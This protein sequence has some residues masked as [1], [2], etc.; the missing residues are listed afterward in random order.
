MASNFNPSTIQR[1]SATE[2]T[3]IL[4]S[5]IF[6]TG[7]IKKQLEDRL[8]HAEDHRSTNGGKK[9]DQTNSVPSNPISSKNIS[10][11]DYITISP[12]K[13]NTKKSKTMTREK[14]K[15]EEKIEFFPVRFEKKEPH[16]FSSNPQLPIKVTADQSHKNILNFKKIIDSTIIN[17]NDDKNSNQLFIDDNL[18]IDYREIET[19]YQSYAID[20]IHIHYLNLSRK[21]D[22]L[23]HAGSDIKAEFEYN[24]LCNQKEIM[25][26]C[27]YIYMQ[28]THLIST[29]DSSIII[30]QNMTGYNKTI[31]D[32]TKLITVDKINDLRMIFLDLQYYSN[33]IFNEFAIKLGLVKKLF[34]NF[35]S[36]PDTIHNKIGQLKNIVEKLSESET[37]LL[38]NF[39][40]K[41]NCDYY[42]EFKRQPG[43]NIIPKGISSYAYH[44][45]GNITMKLYDKE[46][47]DN[48][49]TSTHINNLFNQKYKSDSS[50]IIYICPFCESDMGPIHIK[51]TIVD[52]IP[53]AKGGVDI[54]NMPEGV[55][56]LTSMISNP[57]LITDIPEKFPV[58]L[59]ANHIDKWFKTR[60]PNEIFIPTESEYEQLSDNIKSSY[61]LNDTDQNIFYVDMVFDQLIEAT[62]HN[63]IIQSDMIDSFRELVYETS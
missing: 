52:D 36:V 20:R 30:L 34:K 2:V 44:T 24:K 46:K 13:K 43:G 12:K 21:I 55:K 58:P 47:I 3:Q 4:N 59:I 25:K 28:I 62:P 60:V 56:S 35:I 51:F 33:S 14:P 29:S 31:M 16:S 39:D 6:L 40:P 38:N 9:F 17:T 26:Y 41:I 42:V 53:F 61:N 11:A 1:L 22:I 18:V 7:T 45:V 32:R 5:G 23:D 63:D 19:V 27:C 48:Y 8:N 57:K 54:Y 49:L 15:T 10:L 50:N 37:F